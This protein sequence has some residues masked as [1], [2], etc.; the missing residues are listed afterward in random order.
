MMRALAAVWTGLIPLTFPRPGN[1]SLASF[2]VSNMGG[3]AH[4][5]RECIDDVHLAAS[6]GARVGRQN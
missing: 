4:V 1:W 3:A 2:G 5:V 6:R